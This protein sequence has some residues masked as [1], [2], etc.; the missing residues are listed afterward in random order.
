M[1]D[2]AWRSACRDDSDEQVALSDV[3]ERQSSY[4]RSV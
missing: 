4:R 1:G 3:G 2:H